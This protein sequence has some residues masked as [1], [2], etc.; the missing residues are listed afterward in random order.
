MSSFGSFVEVQ[1]DRVAECVEEEQLLWDV[2][3]LCDRTDRLVRRGGLNPAER[4]R[5]VEV[6]DAFSHEV[7]TL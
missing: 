7:E 6:L 2:L 4:R 5:L 3:A 1:L